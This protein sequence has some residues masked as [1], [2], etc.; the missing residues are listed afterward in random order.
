MNRKAIGK[1]RRFLG[2]NYFNILNFNYIR[3]KAGLA[4]TWPNLTAPRTFSEKIIWLKLNYRAAD[5]KQI[6]DKYRVRE[7]VASRVG[8]D[9]LMPLV[10]TYLNVGDIRIDEFPER[11][12]V[13]PNHASGLVKFYRKSEVNIEDLVRLGK[14]WLAL[15]Y[16]RDGG[17]Y[18]YVG[19]ERRLI[20][21]RDMREDNG[22]EE[23]H[24][25]KFFCFNGV[26]Q[27][28]QVDL[29]RYSHHERCFYNMNWEPQ[30][31][32]LFHP[33]GTADVA[34]PETWDQM[35]SIARELSRGR[36]FARV[37]LYEVSGK[38]YF[39]EITLHPGGGFES[40]TPERYDRE[41]GD[42]LDIGSLLCE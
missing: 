32:S 37:D 28:V 16:G 4:P 25:Y 13:K 26:P 23:L 33:R 20:I 42:L 1:I 15:D 40:F 7:Y 29:N 19:I 17:E 36:P 9:V 35:K 14:E 8:D 39:G 31:F 3:I 27:F 38:V 10:A 30:E 18:Q 2:E 12:V 11:F 24:D 5:A 22:G 21:E 41:I 34:R 6:A